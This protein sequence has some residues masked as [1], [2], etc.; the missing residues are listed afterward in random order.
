[1]T[2]DMKYKASWV[3]YENDTATG[4]VGYF[5]HDTITHGPILGLAFNF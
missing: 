2:L 5:Q 3:D 1:M 4:E